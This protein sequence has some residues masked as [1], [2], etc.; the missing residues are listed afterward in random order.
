[1]PSRGCLTAGG[2]SL[3]W[4]IVVVQLKTFPTLAQPGRAVVRLIN[5]RAVGVLA[6]CVAALS[7][8]MASQRSPASA[9]GSHAVAPWRHAWLLR[10]SRRA[11]SRGS[12]LGWRAGDGL[13]RD[14]RTGGDPAVRGRRRASE[15]RTAGTSWSAS[16]GVVTCRARLTSP[17][18]GWPFPRRRDPLTGR[19]GKPVTELVTTTPVS[20][21][22]ST[23]VSDRRSALICRNRSQRDRGR[24]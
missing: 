16:P 3:S 6:A 13:G 5:M 12:C 19:Y 4:P 8:C 17:C 2:R 7:G 23:T 18:S 11:G 22:P 10:R 21:R 1:M 24:N 15:V 14:T 9:Y 20:D